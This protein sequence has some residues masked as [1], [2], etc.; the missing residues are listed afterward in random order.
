MVAC[1]LAGLLLRLGLVSSY[2]TPSL[3]ENRSSQVLPVYSSA[4]VSGE[5]LDKPIDLEDN[6]CEPIAAKGAFDADI[7]PIDGYFDVGRHEVGFV[8]VSL[9]HGD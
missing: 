4:V 7:E 3:S 6:F 5:V 9:R 1:D 2:G 8:L